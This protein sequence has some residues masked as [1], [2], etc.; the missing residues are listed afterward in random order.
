MR[1]DIVGG[2]I[3]VDRGVLERMVG[4]F[5]HL[6]RNSVAH[7][8]EGAAERRRAG[9]PE[10]GAITITT[11][12]EGNEVA[13]EVRDDGAGLDLARIRA[14]AIERGLLAADAD[15]SEA[16]VAQLIFVPGFSTADAV[17]GLSGRGVG[18]DV[19]RA[20]VLAMGGRIETDTRAGQG[21]AFRLLLPL[22]TAVT[23][24]VMLR[25][26]ERQVA[27]PSTLV[28]VVR[29]DEPAT[30]AD[31]ARLEALVEQAFHDRRKMQRRS[32]AGVASPATK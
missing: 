24:V 6:L 16:E 22:T 11:V 25:F 31:P 10:A 13:V 14:R 9:K 2:S 19:V 27:V 21:T 12:Q 7:G 18:M 5:E 1:L 4:P 8:I 15:P 29:R 17:T 26:G 32:L 23:Q 20:E 3:E 30:D 28:E